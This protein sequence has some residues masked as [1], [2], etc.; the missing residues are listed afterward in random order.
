MNPQTSKH[1]PHEEID[2]SH[3]ISLIMRKPWRALKR[4]RLML[5]ADANPLRS[6]FYHALEAQNQW[7]NEGWFDDY[8]NYYEFGVGWGWTLTRYIEALKS[9]CHDTKID[10]YKFHI[11]GFDSFEGLPAKENPKDGHPMWG[12]GFFSHS[13]QE[14]ENK[15]INEG[16]DLKRG[17]LHLIKGFFKN[18][19]TLELRDALAA[20]P[21]SIVTI[22]LDYY[23]SAKCALEWIR[24][25]LRTGTLFYFDDIWS[26]LG[27]PD[28]GVLA[29]INEFNNSGDDQ[30]IPYPVLGTTSI[31]GKAYAYSKKDWE[32]KA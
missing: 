32:F 5:E 11:Y 17:T 26:F 22:D 19:L 27:N 1:H 10:F 7:K 12:K 16:F 31:L 28:Y 15:L 24:P 3:T 2:S 20:N 18:S 23:S 14:V 21:P 4:I 25:M 29:A 13:V 30:L 6:W 9:F 8:Y